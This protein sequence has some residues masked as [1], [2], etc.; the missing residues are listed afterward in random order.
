[1]RADDRADD[2]VGR[3]ATD[4]GPVPE[5]L[6]D[7][8][9][10]RAAPAVTGTTSAPSSCMRATF[11]AWRRMSSSPMY[12]THGKPEQRARGG[13]GDAVL[14]GAGLGDDPLLAEALREQRLAERVVDLVRA[15][16]ARG[17][18]A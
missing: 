18:R 13:R 14:A 6:V 9:L 7:G 12:T 17:P 15:G 10:Q 2:V 1:M 3:R 11:G 16:V 5:R 8:L 4:G